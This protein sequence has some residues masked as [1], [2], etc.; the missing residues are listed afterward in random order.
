MLKSSVAIFLALLLFAAGVTSAMDLKVG[1]RGAE[2]KA[3]QQKLADLGFDLGLIDGIYGNKTRAAVRQF[4]TDRN[5]AVTGVVDDRT[6]AAIMAASHSP[7][8]SDLIPGDETTPAEGV[9]GTGASAETD[10]DL[11]WDDWDDFG[12]GGKTFSLGGFIRS[13]AAMRF[14]KGDPRY[15]IFANIDGTT[16]TGAR[17]ETG[18][19]SMQQNQLRLFLKGDY[20][21][22]ISSFAAFDLYGAPKPDRPF[23]DK[24]EAEIDELYLDFLWD[25]V[26]L[27]VGKEKIVWGLMDIISPFNVLNSGDLMDPFVNGGLE[28]ARG[29][30][31][32][33]FNYD[34]A[35]DLRAEAVFVPVW[36]PSQTPNADVDEET[37]LTE[38]DFWFPPIFTS[39]P[40]LVW[41]QFQDDYG[42]VQDVIIQNNFEGTVKPKKDLSSAAF[43]ARLTAPVGRF[44]LGAYFVT[45][46]DPK[47][48]P[49][50]KTTIIQG[51]VD[52]GGDL[53]VRNIG[54][55]LLNEIEQQ[56]TRVWIGGGSAET[57]VGRFRFKGE[58][59]LTHGKKFFP[60]ITTA[61]GLTMLYQKAA[62]NVN[63][64]QAGQEEG[65]KYLAWDLL[66]GSEYTIPRADII[67][68]FQL[69]L[70]TRFGHEEYYFGSGTSVNLT[71]FLMKSMAQDQLTTSLAALI[72]ANTGATYLSPRLKFVPQYFDILELGAGFNLFVGPGAEDWGAFKAHKSVLSSY[73]SYSH[74]FG[75]VKLSF[76]VI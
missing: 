63:V 7:A 74:V 27:R 34:N 19:L 1:S 43:G 51:N 3:V 52:F 66:F 45:T 22:R 37:G 31:A 68:S 4:Q 16:Y 12:D 53:G 25:E 14:S 32:L 11:D 39:L 35:G 70:T 6:Y 62:A 33:H 67:T 57:V 54:L 24:V 40:H 49:V 50:I 76:D 75:S 72:E 64:Y 29:Q 44:D 48:N 2:V 71:L 55:G 20:S 10:T 69:G 13:S 60:D 73:G 59:A 8:E 21:S 61:D 30:W 36:N 41:D 47:P 46:L 42:N 15:P 28:D 17:E 18:L 38:S 56:F 23:G 5:L 9:M 26:G 65:E 58:T